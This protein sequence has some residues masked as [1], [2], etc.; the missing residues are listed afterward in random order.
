MKMLCFVGDGNVPVD[1]RQ[2][3][4]LKRVEEARR[5]EDDDILTVVL[6]GCRQKE[7]HFIRAGDI[8]MCCCDN[9][10]DVLAMGCAI[11]SEAEGQPFR[12]W[13]SAQLLKLKTE[14]ER[15]V[16]KEMKT[17]IVNSLLEKG[18]S[19][20]DLQRIM[21]TVQLGPAKMG[22]GLFQMGTGHFT[23]WVASYLRNKPEVARKIGL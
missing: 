4:F 15:E 23:E 21:N 3:A 12:N 22:D 11:D 19:G 17:Q 8:I 13:L 14:T 16:S 9:D 6:K 7:M 18:L 1:T 2:D 20:D 10:L 5:M